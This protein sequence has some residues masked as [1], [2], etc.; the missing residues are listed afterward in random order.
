M[1]VLFAAHSGLKGLPFSAFH[2]VQ[3]MVGGF[4][5][6]DVAYY[7]LLS[8]FNWDWLK[9]VGVRWFVVCYLLASGWWFQPLVEPLII[10]TIWL[11]PCW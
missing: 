8:M 1:V 5:P 4:D 10:T 3:H 2:L 11:E 6:Y 9:Q 7:P